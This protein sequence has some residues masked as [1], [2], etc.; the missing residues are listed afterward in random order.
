LRAILYLIGGSRF[1]SGL[2]NSGLFPLS[3]SRSVASFIWF[4][5]GP[6]KR[7]I[8]QQDHYRTHDCHEKTA[9]IDFGYARHGRPIEK[10][11][12]DGRA[13]NP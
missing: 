6:V 13:D 3:Y 8:N 10:P 1:K 12:C 5:N 2:R 7:M 11:S 9:N 4:S